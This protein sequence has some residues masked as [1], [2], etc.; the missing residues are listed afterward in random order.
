VVNADTPP[1]SL[2]LGSDALTRTRA[3]QA[4]RALDLAAWETTTIGTDFPA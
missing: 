2:V 1:L 3:R 4:Q